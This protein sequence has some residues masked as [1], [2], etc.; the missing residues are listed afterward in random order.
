MAR[1]LAGNQ[2]NRVDSNVVAFPRKAGCKP[3]RRHR[4][5]SQ[6]I[7]VKS[8]CCRFFSAPLLDF[9]EG[10][11]S[12]APSDQVDLSTRNAGPLSQDTPA[13]QAQPPGRDG[14]RLAPPRLGDLPVQLPPPSASARA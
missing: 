11:G 1:E 10:D 3:L 7:L 4:H 14:L 5:A 2:E 9:D 6:A 12:A 13:A 8:Q